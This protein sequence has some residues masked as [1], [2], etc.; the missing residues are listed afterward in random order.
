MKTGLDQSPNQPG[1]AGGS[2]GT[3][4][5]SVTLSEPCSLT[6]VLVMSHPRTQKRETLSPG[7]HFNLDHAIS[8]RK[9]HY[10]QMLILPEHGLVRARDVLCIPHFN[11]AGP[12]WQSSLD[13]TTTWRKSRL[14]F[15]LAVSSREGGM[16]TG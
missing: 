4:G 14:C 16:S 13:T 15:T 11:S 8:Q 12:E 3:R 5:V 7:L 2:T 6:T 10:L 9:Q 1:R